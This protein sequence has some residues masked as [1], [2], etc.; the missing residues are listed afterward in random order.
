MFK[1]SPYKIFFPRTQ[2]STLFQ[3]SNALP[4][5][6]LIFFSL[7]EKFFTVENFPTSREFTDRQRI[8]QTFYIENGLKVNN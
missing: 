6:Q 7:P 5:I 8:D 2:I 4:K 3:L 1:I